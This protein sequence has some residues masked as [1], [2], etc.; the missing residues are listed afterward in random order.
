MTR[1]FTDEHFPDKIVH[2]LRLLGH[3]VQRVRDLCE[4]KEGDGFSDEIVLRHA[5]RT[6]RV[7]VTYNVAHFLNLHERFPW[8]Q[9]IIDC[10]TSRKQESPRSVAKRI[11]AILRERRRMKGA[12]IRLYRKSVDRREH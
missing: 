1:L 5:L 9:G 10:S 8:H 6:K 11:D 4:R 2:Q 12:F 7:T 3:N